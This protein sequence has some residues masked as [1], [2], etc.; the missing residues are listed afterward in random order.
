MSIHKWKCPRG[1]ELTVDDEG[2][3]E[4]PSSQIAVR[5][6]GKF[7]EKCGVY[8]PFGRPLPGGGNETTMCAQPMAKTVEP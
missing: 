1:H 6:M 3:P 2:Q 5:Q 4:S 8:G 7:A